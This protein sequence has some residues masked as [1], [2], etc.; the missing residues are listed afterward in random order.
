MKHEKPK[1]RMI[2]IDDRSS[3]ECLIKRDEKKERYEIRTGVEIS[4]KK[5]HLSTIGN[6]ERGWLC[7]LPREKK[8]DKGHR[9]CVKSSRKILEISGMSPFMAWHFRSTSSRRQRE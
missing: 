7:I 9:R 8:Y 3:L 2:G 4:D 1:K 6:L 5:K